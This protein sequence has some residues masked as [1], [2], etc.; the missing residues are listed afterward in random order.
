MEQGFEKR[1]RIRDELRD[2]FPKSE[3]RF[4]EELIAEPQDSEFLKFHEQELW[5]LMACHVCVVLDVSPGPAAEIAHFVESAGADRLFILTPNTYEGS[6]SFPAEIRA[7]ANQEFFSEEEFTSCNLVKRVIVRVR[8]V[9][10]SR[11]LLDQKFPS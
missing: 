9:A 5:H 4:S 10:F 11:M 2:F 3:V 6:R 7:S 1:K 8:Q